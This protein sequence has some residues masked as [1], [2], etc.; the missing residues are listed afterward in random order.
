MPTPALL[1]RGPWHPD[2]VE[3]RWLDAPF[4]PPADVTRRA[5]ECVDKLR[6]RGS[7]S[8]DGMAARLA[9]YEEDGDR[10]RLDLQP[11]RWALRLLEG[12]AHDS[13]TALCAVRREDGAWLA[14]RRA[15]W[16]ATWAGRWALGAGGAVD[17]GEGPAQTLTRELD[18]EWQ[19][20]PD[21]LS[22][23]AMLR[24]PDGLVMVVG[25]ATVANDV[26]PTPDHEHDAF[27]WWP[28]DPNEWPPEADPRLRLMAAFLAPGG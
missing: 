4:E 26:E 24:L 10:L 27:A 18:E 1:A 15:A 6:E 3:A 11:S 8:H 14:G 28:P 23:E 12:D 25:M 22:V 16:V 19:L 5:D 20:A 17:L 21:Q 9:S 7:P 2:Q 13:L